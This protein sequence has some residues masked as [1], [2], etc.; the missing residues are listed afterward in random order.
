VTR[1]WFYACWLLLA[2]VLVWLLGPDCAGATSGCW[3]VIG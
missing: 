2:G 1:A 3:R